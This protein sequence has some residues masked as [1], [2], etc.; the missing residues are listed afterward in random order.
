M[1]ES[2]VNVQCRV[3][4]APEPRTLLIVRGTSCKNL[5][6]VEPH[7]QLEDE[8]AED[9]SDIDEWNG[10]SP[11]TKECRG[12]ERRIQCLFLFFISLGRTSNTIMTLNSAGDIF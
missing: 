8:L 1:R 4:N 12:G 3:Q 11:L 5:I 9:V 2:C 10:T 7:G 6:S